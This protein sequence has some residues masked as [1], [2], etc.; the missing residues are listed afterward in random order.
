MPKHQK[1]TTYQ[2]QGDDIKITTKS[3]YEEL[4]LMLEETEQKRISSFE[5]LKQDVELALEHVLNDGSPKLTLTIDSTNTGVKLTKRWVTL[6]ENFN[7]R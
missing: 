2:K 7:K 4:A 3:Y 1:V 5:T 6:K